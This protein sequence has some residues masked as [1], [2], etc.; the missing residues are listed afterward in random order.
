MIE[1]TGKAFEKYPALYRSNF[2][3]SGPDKGK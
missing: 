3:V 2:P 1:K